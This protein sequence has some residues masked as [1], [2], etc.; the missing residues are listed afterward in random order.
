MDADGAL[1]FAVAGGDV[2]A[3]RLGERVAGLGR[4][5]DLSGASWAGL[6]MFLWAY[7]GISQ[8]HG[9]GD[10]SLDCLHETGTRTLLPEVPF[11]ATALLDS[12]F[13]GSQTG[14]QDAH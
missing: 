9:P 7:L 4:M 10:D 1:N 8:T 3:Q 12:F 14:A 5:Q 11:F 2:R 6:T 13:R